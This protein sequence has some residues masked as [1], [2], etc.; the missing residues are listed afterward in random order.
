M[1]INTVM[2]S[3]KQHLQEM[4]IGSS[5]VDLF[6][7]DPKPGSESSTAMG[8]IHTQV[9]YG[10]LARVGVTPESD[11]PH[12][13]ARALTIAQ[14]RIMTGNHDHENE[15]LRNL[16]VPHRMRMAADLDRNFRDH[17]AGT[18]EGFGVISDLH[19]RGIDSTPANIVSRF[20]PPPSKY[21]EF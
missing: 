15:G 13:V 3:F 9:L 18:A 10:K 21:I 2:K 8:N 17:I 19:D 5:A 20:P 12:H 16:T 11:H 7:R 14:S 4:K 1:Y 6:G